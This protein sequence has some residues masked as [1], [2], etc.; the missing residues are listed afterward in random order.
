MQWNRHLQLCVLAWVALLD[1]R[2]QVPA[3]NEDHRL[4]PQGDI[5]IYHWA[6]SNVAL[7]RDRAAVASKGDSTLAPGTG[8]V[9][10]H[11]RRATGWELLQK[12]LPSDFVTSVNIPWIQTDNDFGRGMAMYGEWL[13][14]GAPVHDIPSTN[15]GAVYTYRWNGS[16]YEFFQKIQP[17]DFGLCGNFGH[18]VAY[19]GG[20]LFI[21]KP[22][23]DTG[24]SFYGAVYAYRW[25]GA[26]WA[27]LSKETNYDSGFR[28]FGVGVEVDG[29]LLAVASIHRVS[30][31]HVAASGQMNRVQYLVGPIGPTDYGYSMALEGDV[32]VVGQPREP[33]WAGRAYVYRRV[34]GV[35][36]QEQILFGDLLLPPGYSNELGKDVAILRGVIVVG[37]PRAYQPALGRAVGRVFVYEHDGSTWVETERLETQNYGEGSNLGAAVA[38]EDGMILAGGR[39]L[40]IQ[41][42]PSAGA[43]LVYERP[44]GAEVCAGSPTSSGTPATLLVHGVPSVGANAIRL[45]AAGLPGPGLAVFLAGGDVNPPVAVGNGLLCLGSPRRIGPAPVSSGGLSE[46]SVDLTVLGAGGVQPGDQV[47]FQAW[48]RDLTSTGT[49]TSNLTSAV[50]VTFY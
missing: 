48:F 18:G 33:N 5:S 2:A 34:G 15:D 35:F 14:V 22:G 28:N 41:G 12:L 38:I 50:E 4:E 36:V 7:Y 42:V 17:P 10:I 37:A 25:N 20:D 1:V 40:R 13:F 27:F 9:Y 49:P 32:L 24:G 30:L 31:M 29:N 45:K 39:E 6:G 16:R 26:Q 11:L 44:F 47:R 46:R 19:K 3:R 23:D 21:G 43:G 8:A